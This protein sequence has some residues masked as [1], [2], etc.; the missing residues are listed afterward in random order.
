MGRESGVWPVKD[1]AA[2][3]PGRRCSKHER[4]HRAIGRDEKAVDRIAVLGRDAPANEI[5]H[6]HRDERAA[7]VDLARV[8]DERAV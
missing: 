6:E 1:G 2:N 4:E 8:H 7:G 3:D 5:A